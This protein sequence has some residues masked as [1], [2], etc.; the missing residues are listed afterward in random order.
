MRH[1][2]YFDFVSLV[3]L[4]LTSVHVC[5]CEQASDIQVTLCKDSERR[6]KPDPNK[7]VFGH[8]FTDHMFEVEWRQESGWGKPQI[9]PL[10][11]LSLHPAAKVLHYANEVRK[12]QGQRG[13][14]SFLLLFF[15]SFLYTVS[16]FSRISGVRGIEGVLWH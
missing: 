7:L 2:Q 4:I 10:H 6:K 12:G 13:S 8:E 16:L 9:R 15:I 11:N 3:S 1:S 5:V 14:S